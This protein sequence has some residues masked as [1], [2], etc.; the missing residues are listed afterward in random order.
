MPAIPPHWQPRYRPDDGE[1]VG[2]LVPDGDLTVP[3]TIFGAPLADPSDETDAAAVL[4]AEGLA[5]LADRWLLAA[6]DASPGDWNDAVAVA[7]AEAAP[8]RLLLRVVDIGSTEYGSRMPL[9]VPV[10][11]T[12]MRSGRLSGVHQALPPR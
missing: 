12:M 1:L 7:I 5:C 9:P 11:R 3:V 8:D 6:P 4:D 2:Y 10:N